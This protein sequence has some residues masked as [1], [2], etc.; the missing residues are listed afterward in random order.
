MNEILASFI[1]IIIFTILF[2]YHESWFLNSKYIYNE[3]CTSKT[4]K[5]IQF[6]FKFFFWP[7]QRGSGNI[8]NLMYSRNKRIFNGRWYL[9][10]TFIYSV[11]LVFLS[12]DLLNTFLV[13]N[14]KPKFLFIYLIMMMVAI[15]LRY[16]LYKFDGVNQLI[17]ERKNNIKV[18]GEYP[19]QDYYR[20]KK[21]AKL[22][23][24]NKKQ[25][26]NKGE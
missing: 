1:P 3:K 21:E 20:K 11:G 2:S 8:G 10:L 24:K 18:E 12:L 23:N 15:L 25:L 17:Y 19:W 9:T 26:N 22:K 6:L 4:S 16:F 7:E 13:L 5:A 14:H